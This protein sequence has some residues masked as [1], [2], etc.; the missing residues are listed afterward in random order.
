MQTTLI[1]TDEFL[2]LILINDYYPIDKLKKNIEKKLIEPYFHYE[3]ERLVDDIRNLKIESYNHLLAKTDLHNYAKI[4][5]ENGFEIRY[6]PPSEL[7]DEKYIAH[8][9]EFQYLLF[10]KNKM[11]VF[12]AEGK[13]PLSLIEINNWIESQLPND[14]KSEI[15]RKLPY[16]SEIRAEA[17]SGLIT[18]LILHH[19][20]R[21]IP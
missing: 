4:K 16:F 8:S 17:I 2:I 19:W 7:K 18:G 10:L 14:R 9:S 1:S 21:Y 15:L 20:D 11:Q 6:D 12:I 3:E 5:R 13:H